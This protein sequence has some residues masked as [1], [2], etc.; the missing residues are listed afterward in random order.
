M[1]FNVQYMAQIAKDWLLS[2]RIRRWTEEIFVEAR[3]VQRLYKQAVCR[4]RR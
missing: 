4:R 3:H 2:Y 1:K